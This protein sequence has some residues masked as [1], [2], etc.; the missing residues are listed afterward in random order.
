MIETVLFDLDGTIIDTNELIISSFM[1]VFEKGPK[2]PLTR[3]MIIPHMGTTLEY[4]LQ[5]FSGLEKVDDLVPVYRSF[6]L[7][8]HDE[9]VQPFPY[10]HE[11]VERL[12]NEGITMGIVTTKIRPTTLMTLEKFGLEKY[13]ST[14]VTVNDVE[15]PKPHPEPVLTAME[16]LG[17][18]PETTLMVGDST[19]DMQSAKSAG[20]RA[21]GVSWSLKGEALLREH[22]ADYILKDMRDLYDIVLK[23]QE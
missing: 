21:A 1:H 23:N 8:H 2:G 18:N 16:R 15:H 7:S 5:T 10:V 17:A 4:Q 11:V 9:M 14:V 6:N 12:F 13:M 22:G 20:A 19:V 3:D